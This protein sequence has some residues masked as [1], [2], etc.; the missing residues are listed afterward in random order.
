MRISQLSTLAKTA[1]TSSDYL[2]TSNNTNSVNQKL[3]VSN[4]FPTLANSA[5]TSNTALLSAVSNKNEY[6][7]SRIVAGSTKLTVT[8]GGGT[9]D[10]SIDIGTLNFSHISGTISNAQLAGAI[11][12][13]SK[14][15]GILPIANGGTGTTATAYCDLTA[16]VSGTLPTTKGGTGLAS[17]TGNQILYTSSTSAIAESGAAVNGQ[18]LIGNT[19]SRPVWAALTSSDGSVAISNGA[20]TIGLTVTSIPSLNSDITWSAG[21]VR[22]VKPVDTTGA[23]DDVY[24]QAGASTTGA[25][26]T[27]YLRG[28]NTSHAAS[29]SGQVVISTGTG[30]NTIQDITFRQNATSSTTMDVMKIKNNKVGITNTASSHTPDHPLHVI[31]ADTSTNVPP[32]KTEQAD[33]DGSFIIFRGTSASGASTASLATS[34]AT[35]GAKYGAIKVAIDDKSSI[36]HKWIRVYDSAV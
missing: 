21:S 20:G 14:I 16:N 17:F 33:T 29:N 5:A 30:S 27:L 26:G 7:I 31:N 3:L 10:V 4:L 12:L 22:Y 32:I 35:A 24:V 1:V 34:T 8:G 13:T 11:D 25:G 15:T 2:L 19:G 18:V 36:E 28:G 23:A 6:T 9:S